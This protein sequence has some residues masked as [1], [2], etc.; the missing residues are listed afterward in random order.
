[1][2]PTDLAGESRGAGAWSRLRLAAASLLLVGL[3]LAAYSNS[4]Q[5]SWHFDDEP[6]ITQNSYVHINTLS[7]ASLLGAMLQDRRQN[8]P[9][10]NLSF[11]LN[12]YFSG[13]QVFAYHLVN[14]LLHLL[15]SLLVFFNL[16]LLFRRAGLNRDRSDPAALAAAA[17]WT[18][19]PLNVQAVTYIVQ[20]QTVMASVLMLGALLAYLSARESKAP[21][22]RL[23]LYG[24]SALAFI[25]AAGS[26]EIALVTP[27][28]ILLVEFYFYQ[29]LSPAFLRRRPL[30]LAAALLLFS[31]L[32]LLFLRAPMRSQIAHGFQNFPFTLSQ[33]LLTEPRVLYSYLGLTLWPVPLSVEHD[34]LVSWSWLHPW[35][36]APALLGWTVILVA[37]IL[38][39]RSYPWLSFAALWY[40]LNL[41]LE[42]SFLPLDLMFEH[43]LYLPSLAVIVPLLAG[44]VFSARRL[45]RVWPLLALLTLML[46]AMTRERNRVWQTELD[47]WRDCARKTPFK[48]AAF[49]N[50]GAAF[51]EAGDDD[52]A[53]PAFDRAVKLDPKSPDAFL[54]RGIAYGKKG[55]LELA[56]LDFDSALALNPGLAKVY[57]NRGLA[58]AE[59]GRFQAA[60]ADWTRA[61]ELDPGLTPAY[62]SRGSLYL[63]LGQSRL[64]QSDFL[65]ARNQSP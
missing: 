8:R 19:H 42:S 5:A 51:R 14:L 28:L 40:L 49:I 60:L 38:K 6:N 3:G 13:Q 15:G 48:A 44:P 18:V 27:A 59:Q 61:I 54:N 22:R 39:A 52:R 7:L 29:G 64:A 17:V 57:Y 26:K 53:F 47:L 37:A 2:L 11:A 32:V 58:L 10:S 21:G 4:L 50:L 31:G 16:R 33:R 35:T 30:A 65:K 34:P 45:S 63:R 41:S 25:L 23:L 12:Y 62:L 43:R 55:Q 46:L 36:T 1:M 20:R 9:F 56:L 24:G